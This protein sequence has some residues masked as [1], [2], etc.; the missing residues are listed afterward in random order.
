[1][2]DP[3][4]PLAV[5]LVGCGAIAGA[6]VQALRQVPGLRLGAA[7]DPDPAARQR[8]ADGGVPVAAS[9]DTLP[10][11]LRL[12]AALLLT[13]P[14]LHESLAV[15]LL[16]RGLHVLC[17][18]PLATGVAAAERML[19]AARAAGRVLMMGSKFRFTPDVAAAHAL[20][21]EGVCG[22]VVLYENVFCSHVDMTRRWN[23]VPAHSGGGVLIDNGCHSVDLARFLLGPIASVQATFGRRVQPIPVEDTARLAFVAAGGALGAIDL[24]WSVHKET[25][26]Y[27]RVHGTRGVLEVGW[28]GSRCKPA[29]G[30]WRAFGHGYDKIQAFAAQLQN[31]AGVV[32]G[33][34]APVIGDA[35]ALASVVVIDTA[36]RSAAEQRW[37]PVPGAATIPA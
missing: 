22:D 23:A 19:A 26:H 33:D 7:V 3:G 9:V 30:G 31:F 28:R 4:E 1:M 20:L 15:Q 32:R 37:L 24:S 12:A 34:E 18:K 21:A 8:F 13:P 5:V 2:R 36:Y 35:D 25:D 17:E 11:G 27:V 14:H 16:H 10:A 6:Y 29:G